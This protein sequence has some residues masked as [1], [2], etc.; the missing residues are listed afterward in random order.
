MYSNIRLLN[1]KN[2]VNYSNIFI[3]TGTYKGKT[4]QKALDVGYTDVSSIEA[5]LNLYQHCRF[6]FID[7]GKVKLYY[8]KSVDVLP[9]ILDKLK[10]RAIFW[11]DAHVTELDSEGYKDFKEK[12]IESD[13]HQHTC[14]LKELSLILS[15]RKDHIILIDDQ[16]GTDNMSEVY[17]KMIKDANSD[18]QFVWYDEDTGENYYTDKILGAIPQREIYF[19]L[20]KNI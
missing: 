5:D 3:E 4:V 14:L 11:L 13:Y 15:H 16:H 10:H 12:G 7:N 6:R 18:Y 20:T 1:F 2:F 17:K 19:S 9:S 8:G